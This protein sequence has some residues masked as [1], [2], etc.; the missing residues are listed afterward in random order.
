MKQ[1]VIVGSM[2]YDD[3]ETPYGKS[4]KVLGGAATYSSL[5]SSYFNVDV[6]IISIVGGDFK[7]EYF[8]LLRSHGI[9][10][11]GV[12]IH[13]N[14]KTFYWAGKYYEDMNRRQTLITDLN[15]LEKFDPVVPE[16]YKEPDILL[17]AN[18]SPVVQLKV[19]NQLKRRPNLIVLDTMDFWIM[20]ML[21]ELTEV[22][23]K[24]DVLTINDQE[25]FLLSGEHTLRAAANKILDMGPKYIIIKKGE[26]GALLF[27]RE[28]A[29]FAPALPLYKVFD[30]TGAGDTFAGG[31][32]G[33]IA[34]TDDISFENLKN[35]VIAGSVLASFTVEDFGTKRLQNLKH[36]DIIER[37]NEFIEL[38]KFDFPEP[39]KILNKNNGQ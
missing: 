36:Q 35:G 17:L 27:S 11:E 9:D 16:S 32:C 12:D 23:E 38:V 5:A 6:K 4:G 37:I 1:V 29:F 3:I 22:I 33:F 30:P 31:F 10:L 24:I 34:T 21:E 14:E 8:D 13:E 39:T 15:V 28:K 19:I 7:K 26:H 20:T 25:A 2:A 18:L